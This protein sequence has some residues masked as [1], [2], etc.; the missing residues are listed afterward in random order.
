M[1][2]ASTARDYNGIVLFNYAPGIKYPFKYFPKEYFE[3]SEIKEAYYL[4]Q[5]VP[6]SRMKKLKNLK[7]HPGESLSIFAKVEKGK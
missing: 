2:K 3:S 5:L 1:S 6:N 4:F 7:K